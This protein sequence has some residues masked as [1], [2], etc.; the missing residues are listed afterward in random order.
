MIETPPDFKAYHALDV[1]ARMQARLNGLAQVIGA[2]GLEVLSDAPSRGAQP[3]VLPE[4][5]AGAQAFGEAERVFVSKSN[6]MPA[7]TDDSIAALA[8]KLDVTTE[9]LRAALTNGVPDQ[10]DGD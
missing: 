8:A 1:T 3:G 9:A 4:L 7:L 10:S 2:S 5:D 6:V